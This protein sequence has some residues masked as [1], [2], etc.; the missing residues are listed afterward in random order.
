LPVDRAELPPE[1]IVLDGF[2]LRR[3]QAAD[4]GMIADSVAAN[5]S[6]LAAWMPWAGPVSATVDGQRARIPGTM[7]RWDEG[8][9]YEYLAVLADTSRHLGNFGLERRIG[10]GALEIGYWLTQDAEGHGYAT[11]AARALTD[12]A[13]NL[14]GIARVEIHCDQANLR[15]QAIPQRLGYRLDRIE[16]AEIKA[17][18]ETGHS[19]I[20]IYDRG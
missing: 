16:S 14:P 2:V 17:A 12:V 13:L 5:L 18:N 11:A 3:T 9:A 10:P 19:M 15:S 6:R 8:L 7:A 1:R 20:W 4:A